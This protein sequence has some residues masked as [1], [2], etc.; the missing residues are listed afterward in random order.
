MNYTFWVLVLVTF[1]S[2]V[3]LVM[4]GIGLGIDRWVTFN[5]PGEGNPVVEVIEP[6]SPEASLTIRYFISNYGAFMGCINTN[7]TSVEANSMRSISYIDRMENIVGVALGLT[8]LGIRQANQTSSV[9]CATIFWNCKLGL[10]FTSSDNQQVSTQ[11]PMTM[12]QDDC[13]VFNAVR[14]M[15]TIGGFFLLVSFVAFLASF[16][17]TSRQIFAAAMSLTGFLLILIAFALWY[18]IL[19]AGTGNDYVSYDYAMAMFIASFPMALLAGIIIL[20]RPYDKKFELHQRKQEEEEAREAYAAEQAAL[21][22][23]QQQQYYD[24]QGGEG[25][26][27]DQQG[28]EGGYYDEQG[29]AAA[30]G[31]YDEQGYYVEK[32]AADGAYDN[33]VPNEAA[34]D[35]YDRPQ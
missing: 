31:Y 15:G 4:C 26:Y 29:Q 21:A 35:N 9:A 17:R 16:K 32:G 33:A 24:Q 19:F 30:G 2:L 22:E 10:T 8:Q 23:Q 20:I 28:Q 5:K 12:L 13:S 14:C 11:L 6:Y 7:T 3:S 34:N 27:Y 18:G 1:I 25:Q